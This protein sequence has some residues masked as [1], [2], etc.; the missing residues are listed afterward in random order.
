MQLHHLFLHSF[1]NI[2]PKMDSL[3][4]VPSTADLQKVEQSRSFLPPIFQDN[5]QNIN[6]DVDLQTKPAFLT[7][8]QWQRM[9]DIY[10]NYITGLPAVPN[11]RTF[12]TA[13][14]VTYTDLESCIRAD[15]L[16]Y[17]HDELVPLNDNT[18][19]YDII[20]EC[21]AVRWEC[22]RS[23]EDQPLAI[24]EALFLVG[25]DM[26]CNMSLYYWQTNFTM[27]KLLTYYGQANGQVP[28]AGI[29]N[30]IM[31]MIGRMRGFNVDTLIRN[32][33]IAFKNEGGDL[34]I[35]VRGNKS[36]RKLKGLK[37]AAKN[38]FLT[39]LAKLSYK[40]QPKGSAEWF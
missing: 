5:A 26:F 37:E 31:A 24:T 3:R 4:V 38:A 18:S 36:M 39:R 29:N 40:L 28:D 20:I 22:I 30:Y 21:D 12:D 10:R 32:H 9:A 6:T 19:W 16:M 33:V 34:A 17:Y 2:A 15:M 23:Y 25:K 11:I 35:D 8:E 1:F 27:T 14:N 7:D 13:L